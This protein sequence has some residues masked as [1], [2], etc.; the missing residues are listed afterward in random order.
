MGFPWIGDGTTRVTAS[1]A[2][3]SRSGPPRAARKGWRRWRRQRRRWR[4]EGGG[5]WCTA[6]TS[7]WASQVL[8]VSRPARSGIPTCHTL[9][10]PIVQGLDADQQ[11][12]QQVVECEV[13]THGGCRRRQGV[14]V[15]RVALSAG[16]KR[17]KEETAR[18][19]RSASPRSLARRYSRVYT[20]EGERFPIGIEVPIYVRV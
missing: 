6:G 7:W 17:Q 13:G 4:V 20:L 11:D 15:G 12:Q 14:R 16:V 18:V 9:I 3:G 10:L 2:S 5:G 1:P 19:R 8:R